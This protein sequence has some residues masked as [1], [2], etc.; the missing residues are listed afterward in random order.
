[1]INIVVTSKPVDGLLHY[2]YEYCCM[3]NDAGIEAQVVIITRGDY[4]PQH[5]LDSLEK[6]Y[7]YVKNV[8]IN[9]CWPEDDDVTMILGRS[10]I[11]IP[12][13]ERDLYDD[14][15][16]LLTHLLFNNKLISVYSTNDNNAYDSAL[17]HF[18]TQHVYD[19]CD[20]DVYPDGV[21]KH[22]EKTIN[23]SMYKDPINDVQ[24]NH[25]FLGT[26]REYYSELL[27]VVPKYPD[28]GILSYDE[29]YINRDWNNI[30]CPV[31]N[32]LGIFETYVYNKQTFD[33]APRLFMECKYYGKDIIYLRNF[34]GID[35]GS[36]YWNRDPQT[37]D[38]QP[39]IEAY[40][41]I[42]RMG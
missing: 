1:M 18:D 16:K 4:K 24:F 29:D 42:Q 11:S 33:P 38:I 3:L 15:R 25:L 17:K 2:S 40:N 41:E 7:R 36:V 21:G 19:L 12:Y 31:D 28:H 20:T 35:G 14:N 39:I 23:F 32:V 34:N 5:Y 9:D 13:K 10:M 22:F 8:E 27:D 30:F 6:K 37:P 26:N